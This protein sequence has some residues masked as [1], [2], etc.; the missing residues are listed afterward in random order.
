MSDIGKT[1]V[2]IQGNPVK[3]EILGTNQDG[4]VLTWTNDDGQWEAQPIGGTTPGEGDL[5]G[6]FPNQ[7]VTSLTG[8][9]GIF[10]FTE[11]TLT[12][13]NNSPIIQA[14]IE[15]SITLSTDNI[16]GGDNG[17]INIITGTAPTSESL[18]CHNISLDAGAQNGVS[19]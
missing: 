10:L 13:T 18:S 9:V 19:N 8:N 6:R 11:L 1:V 12:T 5:S 2:A 3:R 7:I 17:P 14:T 16:N 15:D 4:Y